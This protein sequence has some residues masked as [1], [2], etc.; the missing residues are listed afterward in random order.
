MDNSRQSDTNEAGPPPRKTASI[1][2]PTWAAFGETFTPS[3]LML[4]RDFDQIRHFCF[5][6][7]DQISQARRKSDGLVVAIRTVVCTQQ[8]R[9]FAPGLHDLIKILPQLNHPAI[10][11]FLGHMVQPNQLHIV[12]DYDPQTNS[13]RALLDIRS[14]S[15][16]E[17]G[18]C[19]VQIAGALDYIHAK[20]AV[21]R[22]LDPSGIL[23]MSGS[24]IK[25]VALHSMTIL[26]TNGL[27]SGDY[28]SVED[29]APETLGGGHY[30]THGR[31]Q[32]L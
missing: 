31:L 32:T 16:D 14:F 9:S 6:G 7:L 5:A 1:P 27:T 12:L 21:A 23:L 15:E 11:T 25:L 8:A 24:R 17:V 26:D 2:F 29:R 19:A 18:H 30:G 22:S 10:V 28:G 20:G 13:L 4:L 3:T